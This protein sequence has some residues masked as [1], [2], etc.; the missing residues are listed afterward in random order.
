MRA[1]SVQKVVLATNA[2]N[3]LKSAKKWALKSVL[4]K[5]QKIKVM[6]VAAK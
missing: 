2:G 5:A 4:K 3:V 1:R 6:V